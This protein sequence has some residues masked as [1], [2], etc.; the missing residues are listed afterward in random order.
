MPQHFLKGIQRHSLEYGQNGKRVASDVRGDLDPAV[1]FPAYDSKTEP[2]GI[3][4]A[5]RKDTFGRVF[6]FIRTPVFFNQLD[7]NG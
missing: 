4:F 2:H 6:L 3:V 7:G 5:Y 1:A